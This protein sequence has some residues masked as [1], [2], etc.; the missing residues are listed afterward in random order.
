MEWI[1]PI[2]LCEHMKMVR[3]SQVSISINSCTELSK[4]QFFTVRIVKE[5]GGYNSYLCGAVALTFGNRE[6]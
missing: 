2:R 3:S 4:A 1:E 5:L 6:Y